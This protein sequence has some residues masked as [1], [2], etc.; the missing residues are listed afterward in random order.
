M[1][2]DRAQ[3]EQALNAVAQLARTHAVATILGME[4]ITH[5]GRQIAP[6]VID[7]RGQ[8]LGCQ[9]LASRYAPARYGE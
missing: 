6:F 4:R 1:P 9:T 8:V 3:Q 2:F 7:D 5:A